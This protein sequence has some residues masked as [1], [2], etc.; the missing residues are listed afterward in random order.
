MIRL[1][2][3]SILDRTALFQMNISS[4]PQAILRL[5]AVA[6]DSHFDWGSYCDIDLLL[7]C[8]Q[9]DYS[10]IRIWS[11]VLNLQFI[12]SC[13]KFT[14][15]LSDFSEFTIKIIH[16]IFQMTQFFY[17]WELVLIF[18]VWVQSK[19]YISLIFT[20]VSP[21]VSSLQNEVIYCFRVT[22]L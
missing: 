9:N 15:L 8:I 2:F 6:M 1:V 14:D 12:M 21:Y 13:D 18:W 7:P 16:Q 22:F 3:N 19:N 17:D 10:L 4:Q 20:Y 5:I 11:L